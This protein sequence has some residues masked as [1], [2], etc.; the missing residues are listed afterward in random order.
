MNDNKP[1]YTMADLCKRW[2]CS[3]RAVLVAVERGELETFRL[4]R[5]AYRF[6]A[7]AVQAYE[8]RKRSA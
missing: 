6:T 2:S 3:R 1:V 8:Q 4:G 7:E 5:R